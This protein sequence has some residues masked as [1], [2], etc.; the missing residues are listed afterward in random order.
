MLTI[1]EAKHNGQSALKLIGELTIYS[2]SEAKKGLAKCSDKKAPQ[3]LDLSGIEEID[4]A[5]VQV[6]LWVKR[7]ALGHKK[8]LAFVNHSVA[9]VEAFDLLKV[10]SIF[11]DPILIAPSGN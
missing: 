1:Q 9:V 8:A 11:G 6:L 5:G 4:T 3:E 10:T 7:E 2:A